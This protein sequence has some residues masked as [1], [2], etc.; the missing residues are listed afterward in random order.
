MSRGPKC[1]SQNGAA[2][3]VP[4][5]KWWLEFQQELDHLQVPADSRAVQRSLAVAPTVSEIDVFVQQELNYILSS[6]AAGKRK[7]RLYLLLRRVAFATA[8]F[9]KETLDIV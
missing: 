7:R 6:P 3:N 2:V 8:I 4:R 1:L 5:F 9:I